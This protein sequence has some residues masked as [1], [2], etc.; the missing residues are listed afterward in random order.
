MPAEL[1]H[2]IIFFHKNMLTGVFQQSCFVTI[3]SY[4]YRSCQLSCFCDNFLKNML[5][6]EF[7][8]S[9][10]VTILSLYILCSLIYVCFIMLSINIHAALN[11]YLCCV[12]ANFF[13]QVCSIEP[14]F[15]ET[16]Y[17]RCIVVPLN[18]TSL[19][20]KFNYL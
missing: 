8:L 13:R 9:C 14:S 5:T 12:H 2:T 4:A 11:I 1:I 16:I 19:L 6:G 20:V 3:L 15:V 10:F 17:L 18:S 7:L